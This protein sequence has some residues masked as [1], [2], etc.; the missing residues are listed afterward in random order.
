[1]IIQK[2]QVFGARNVAQYLETWASARATF[3]AFS[4][5][6]LAHFSGLAHAEANRIVGPVGVQGV[7]IARYRGGDVLLV[8]LLDPGELRN[9]AALAAKR[10]ALFVRLL[11]CRRDQVSPIRRKYFQVPSWSFVS[12]ASI[13]PR[14]CFGSP[15]GDSRYEPVK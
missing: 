11:P 4:D 14:T 2:R 13:V 12:T 10:C 9:M 1:M 5:R 8:E 7:S 6:L 15:L 3:V